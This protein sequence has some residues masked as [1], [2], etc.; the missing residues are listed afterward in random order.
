MKKVLTIGG[1]TQDIIVSYHDAETLFL[2]NQRGGMAYI[3]LEEGKKIELDGLSQF[4]G[5][6]ATNS[7]VALKRQGFDVSVLCKVGDDIAG[8]TIQ[9]ELEGYGIDISKIM[10][11]MGTATGSSVVVPSPSGDR[12]VMAYRGANANWHQGDVKTDKL[13]GF[14][15]LYITSL[16]ADTALMLPSLVSFA[17]SRGINVAANPGSSQL[18]KGADVLKDSLPYIDTLIL[19]SDEAKQMMSSL[20]KLDDDIRG[21][22]A[23]QLRDGG[24][25]LLDAPIC[26][27]D[28][29]FSLR[30]FFK[31]VLKL[32]PQVVVVTDGDKG[33]YV[34]TKEQLYFHS[35]L[36]VNN[37]I[38]TLGAGDAF[39][40]SF[41][42]ALAQG[43][44]IIDAIRYGL[45]NS[46]N[47]IQYPDAKTGLLESEQLDALVG[48]L[49]KEQFDIMS[50]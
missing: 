49:P 44:D 38:N 10:V 48:N 20:I 41:V 25:L 26:Y 27:Q 37:V 6:G 43:K 36:K 35:S 34:A 7:A 9:S 1:A 24:E 50:W 19:N 18:T 31:E 42:G 22:I 5:G 15:Q 45:C 17:K 28:V 32:G 4:S 13:T 46:A 30:Q 23:N 47:V 14:D 3:L 11:D 12:T 29:T 40:S 8:R 21:K 39:G 2:R 16:S 33:V